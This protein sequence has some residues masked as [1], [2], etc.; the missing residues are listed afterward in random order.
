MGAFVCGTDWVLK[1]GFCSFWVECVSKQEGTGI[2]PCSI[3]KV[4]IFNILRLTYFFNECY[5]QEFNSTLFSKANKIS[6]LA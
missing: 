2:N 5:K 4:L 6:I 3:Y 1:V